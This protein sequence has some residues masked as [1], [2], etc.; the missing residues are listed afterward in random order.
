MLYYSTAQ[1]SHWPQTVKPSGKIGRPAAQYALTKIQL[2]YYILPK[3]AKDV[4]AL[5]TENATPL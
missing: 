4:R 5:L 2:Q 3:F 1:S